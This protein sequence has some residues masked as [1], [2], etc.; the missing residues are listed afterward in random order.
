MSREEEPQT[1]ADIPPED[2]TSKLEKELT[3]IRN[4][5]SKGDRRR[6]PSAI[7]DFVLISGFIYGAFYALLIFS[8]S[9]GLLGTSTAL[10][11]AASKTFLDPSG[12]CQEVTD[13]P[14]IHIYP[15][16][17][18]ERFSIGVYNLPPGIA[19]VSMTLIAMDVI[20]EET[21]VLSSQVDENFTIGSNGSLGTVFSFHHLSS[22][23]YEL[24]V[25]V[26][27]QP[28]EGSEEATVE[29]EWPISNDLSVELSTSSATLSFL[30][31]VDDT[32][33]TEATILEAGQRN[34]WTMPQ[35]GRWGFVLM[36]AELGGG[37][38][39]AMLT[40]G[41]AGIP[42]WWMAFI[43]LSLSAVS[44]LLLYP[45]MYK[46]YHQD[47]DDMLSNKHIEHLV[48]N[49]V[50]KVAARLDI[51]IDWEVYKAESRQLSID[52]MVPYGTTE[53]TLSDNK[54]VRAEVLR[55]LLEEFSLFR[56]FK[57]VQLTVRPVDH[58]GVDLDS[59]IGFG[60]STADEEQ[61][62][63]R[64]YSAFFGEL[65]TLA[66]VEEEVRDSLD[67]FFA[68]RNNVTMV[69][70]VVTSDDRHI[71]VSTVYRPTLRLAF[72]RFKTTTE[73]VEQELRAF[74]SSR[75]EDLLHSQDL[76][77]K[78]RNQVSPSPT[79]PVLGAWNS[80]QATTNV[81]PLSPVKTDWGAGSANEIRRRPA[82]HGGI[83]GQREA[84]I[85]QQV[86][87]L[88][89]HP[90]CLD[91]VH[92]LGCHCGI[93]AR[94]ALAHEVHARAL[95]GCHRRFCGLGHVGLHRRRHH[96]LHARL[97]VGSDD[98]HRHRRL[99]AHRLPPHALDQIAP[100]SRVVRRHA[101]GQLPRRPARQ[102]RHRVRARHGRG[103][104]AL[105]DVRGTSAN[106]LASAS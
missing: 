100:P 91:S 32:D 11:H 55:D 16:N 44:L 105:T 19:N 67:L 41:A 63:R 69:G 49:T 42:A 46:V 31:F 101:V 77:L 12:E 68:R 98:S 6:F 78:V 80:P 96:P 3:I 36:G 52:I 65:H 10:D 70:A 45:L 4:R 89:P 29:G 1:P 97:Q 54:D 66:R 35:L 83:H 56:V 48:K 22:G 43:S 37:R 92:G 58:Q 64:D 104:P 59:G 74:I 7:E 13:E 15:D 24:S 81:W 71:F 75:N 50:A 26:D 90:V 95:G 33:H 20:G 14:W 34:C 25:R 102:V 57:P 47:T 62:E 39:T 76:I 72:F 79:A 88:G 21:D 87:L 73:E 85:H 30:P 2:G 84:G 9:G 106:S 61:P 8:M 82:V 27:M 51:T 38:E 94:H 17:D 53:N 93:D 5:R 28:P 23:P 40:G 103:D 18:N 86:G 99:C 60:G